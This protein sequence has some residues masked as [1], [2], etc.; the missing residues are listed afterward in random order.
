MTDAL[1]GLARTAVPLL[2][3]W[4]LGF[5]AVQALGLT[6]EQ[7]TPLISAG[8]GLAYWLVVR[9]LEAYVTPRFGWLLGYAKAPTYKA[10]EPA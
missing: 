2:V 7:V 8:V 4:L 5:K 6:E 9:V 10:V 3:G 1:A